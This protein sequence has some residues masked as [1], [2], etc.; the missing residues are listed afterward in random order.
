VIVLDS[1]AFL[2]LLKGEPAASRVQRLVEGEEDTALTVLGVSEVLDHL[3]R[4]VGVDEEE[5]VLDVAQLGLATPSSIE[6]GLGLRAGLLRAR[7]YHRKNRAV[8][9][10]DCFAAETARPEG[11]SLAS[12]DPHLL[13]LCRDE[14]ISV[15]ALPDS[16]GRT[17]KR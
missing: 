4:V 12:A 5:A 15:I 1:Y 14:G 9:L 16:T 13:D 7:H 8:S 2:A 3:V 11:S 10:A 17:W 6:A